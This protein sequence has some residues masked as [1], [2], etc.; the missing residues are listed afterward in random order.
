MESSTG[1]PLPHALKHNGL[2]RDKIKE[3]ASILT[4][5]A[6]VEASQFMGRYG[7][8]TSYSYI[9]F[10]NP[11]DAMAFKLLYEGDDQSS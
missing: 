10:E 4:A 11:E 8:K 9:Y 6:Y 1:V 2:K 7:L 5:P 3:I